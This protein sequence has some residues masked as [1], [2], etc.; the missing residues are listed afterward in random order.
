MNIAILS[1][2]PM[3]PIARHVTKWLASSHALQIEGH[4]YEHIELDVKTFANGEIL[5]R[6]PAS[7]RSKRVYLFHSPQLPNPNAGLME[8]FLTINALKLAWVEDIVL[9]LPFIPYGRQDKKEDDERVPISARAIADM[10]TMSGKVRGIISMDFHVEQI[11]GFFSCPT[12]NLSARSIFAEYFQ[13]RFAGDFSNVI[14]SSTDMGGGKKAQRFADKLE[15][16]VG[17][18]L[19]ART[20]GALVENKGYIGPDLEGKSVILGDDILDTANSMITGIKT[21][22]DRGAKEVLVYCSHGVFSPKGES[23][24]ESKLKEAGAEV[25]SLD[26]IPRDHDYRLANKDWLT[27]LSVADYLAKVVCENHRSGG[28]VSSLG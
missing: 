21:V 11:P 22:R 19:K 4:T 28:S 16:P 8:L 1:S 18:L 10:L 20:K 9:V 7:V 24:A 6:I 25:V 13:T 3:S 14:V 12:Q 15:V 26:T 27:V 2:K 23:T 17:T 5:P